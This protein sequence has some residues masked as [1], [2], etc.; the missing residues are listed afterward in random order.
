MADVD[1]LSDG[2][3]LSLHALAAELDPSRGLAVVTEGLLNY[4]DR[5]T[6]QRLWRRIAGLLAGFATGVY[7]SDIVLD[8]DVSG[9]IPRAFQA[10]LSVFVRGRVHLHFAGEDELEGAL[11]ACGFDSVE[12]HEAA[13]AG[14]ADDPSVRM[15]R[16][17]EARAT[18]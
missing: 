11:R 13:Y 5:D 4:F 9:L 17:I 7:L 3:S 16:V 6:V 18:A 12:V 8:R 15:V 1:A 14:P 2:G 10:A